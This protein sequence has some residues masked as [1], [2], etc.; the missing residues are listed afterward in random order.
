MPLY[1]NGS[2]VQDAW[3]TIREGEAISPAGHVIAPLAWWQAER[4]AF[5]QSHVPIG[6][7]I[8][9]GASIDD[10]IADLPHLALIALVIPKFQD[11]RP[12]SMARLLRERHGFKGE[13]RATGEVLIDQIQPML[14]CGFDAFEITDPVTQAALEAGRVP[15]VTHFYQPGVNEAPQ[16]GARPWLRQAER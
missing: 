3:T 4:Q 11:G 15:G 6:V 9:P 10:F 14:R 7:L 2:F 8:E 12:Y 13:V 16:A 5:D 1:K